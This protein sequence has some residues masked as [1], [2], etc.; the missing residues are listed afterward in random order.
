M[1]NRTG[2]KLIGLTGLILSV[3]LILSSCSYSG[4]SAVKT[5][6]N[7]SERNVINVPAENSEN[8]HS[9][10]KKNMKGTKVASGLIELRIDDTN[11][12]CGIWDSSSE[13]LWSA[14]PVVNS[15][16]EVLSDC[17]ASMIS[18]RIAGGSDVYTLNS[19]DN[20]VAYKK[21]SY[22]AIEN[23][24]KFIY[25]IFSSAEAAKAKKHSASDIG[26]RVELSIVLKDGS[27]SATCTYKNITGNKNA[28]I[29]SI[30]VMNCFGAYSETQG[31]NFLLVPDGCGAII[32]TSVFDESFESLSY[33]VYG[34]DPSLPSE[35][36]GNAIIPAFGIKRENAAFAVLIEEGGASATIKADK[37]KGNNALNRVY[38]SVGITPS[39]YEDDTIYI[40]EKAET[41]SIVFCYRFLSGI[42][43]S[44]AGMASAIR[45]QLIRN[46]VITTDIIEPTDHLPFFLSLN[47]TAKSKGI[48]DISTNKTLTNT[49]Q[50]QDMLMRMKNK[51]I[52]NIVVRY[53][54]ILSGGANQTDITKASILSSI[55]GK[56]GLATLNEYIKSQNLNLYV[57][58][59]LLSSS[60]RISGKKA[61]DIFN[62]ESSYTPQSSIADEM[63][64]D[65]SSRVLR[66]LSDISSM[67][68]KVLTDT[69]ELSSSGICIDDAGQLLYS[70][71]SKNGLLR[72][73]ASKVISDSF[74]HLSTENKIMIDGGNFYMLRNAECIINLPLTTSVSKS[75]SYTP[76]PFVQLIL[77]GI[78]DYTGPAINVGINTKDTLLKFVEYGACPHYEWNYESCMS[79][80][81]SDI[82]FYNNTIN[83]AADYYDD[84][85]E[86]LNDLRDARITDHY[87]VEDGVFCTEYDSGATIYVN[88]TDRSCNILGATV[89]SH[90]F[91]RVNQGG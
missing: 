67:L 60:G 88:Y 78:C 64:T 6:K 90:S 63:G 58:V 76:V 11:Y 48:F 40:S 79:E 7:V 12:S 74:R 38:A 42:N 33:P 73:E 17:T 43:A 53:S 25:D 46:S 52:S 85:D 59:N 68:I 51:G 32:N 54:S 8:Y 35:A 69:K 80:S 28:F 44:Y 45:E 72:N 55:G 36:S 16:D 10:L 21:A 26:F 82:F 5:L 34:D 66:C 65:V 61:R 86:N 1:I 4:T 19:Q 39:V 30:E 31:D 3:C 27:M 56:S 2:K 24:Y 15:K 20:S 9:S 91:L 49:E 29:E 77:H 22:K 23:G 41:E 87:E 62:S 75:G 83:S 14:L 89:P 50:A 84:I 18:L 57:N 47:G 37:S 70:D 81:A 71:Y 13:T